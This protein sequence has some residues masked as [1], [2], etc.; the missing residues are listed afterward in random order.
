MG[1]GLEWLISNRK[2]LQAAVISHLM[3]VLFIAMLLYL[4][5]DNIYLAFLAPVISLQIYLYLWFPEIS[6]FPSLC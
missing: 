6:Y 1:H 4:V 5:S 2:Q 3:E